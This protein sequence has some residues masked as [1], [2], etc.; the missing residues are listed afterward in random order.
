MLSTYV[1]NS[2]QPKVYVGDTDYCIA[3]YPNVGEE[4]EEMRIYDG[5]IRTTVGQKDIKNCGNVVEG[6]SSLYYAHRYDTTTWEIW[7]DDGDTDE[8][9]NVTYRDRLR[10]YDLSSDLLWTS[11]SVYEEWDKNTYNLTIHENGDGRKFIRSATASRYGAKHAGDNGLYFFN[12]LEDLDFE[13]EYLINPSSKI[14]YIYAPEGLS[15]KEI[16]VCTSTFS[17]VSMKKVSN[18]LLNGISVE[19]SSGAGILATESENVLIQNC[20]FRNLGSY[21]VS[22]NTCYNSGVTYSNFYT[23]TGAQIDSTLTG[24]LIPNRCFLQNNRFENATATS[25]LAVRLGGVANV[26]S[27]HYF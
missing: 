16:T 3:R 2:S 22:F 24:Q 17:P 13:G 6:I 27:H 23:C 19:R 26:E 12:M 5:R 15:G 21:G 4:N 9:N 10:G 11:A 7:L 25:T 20:T 8:T 1:N 14:L 18:V